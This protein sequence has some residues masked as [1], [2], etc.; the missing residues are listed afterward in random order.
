[1]VFYVLLYLFSCSRQPEKERFCFKILYYELARSRELRAFLFLKIMAKRIRTKLSPEFWAWCACRQRCYNTNAPFYTS[2]GGRGIV[3]C[4]RWCDKKHGFKNF[5]LDMGKRPSDKHSL[6]RVDNNGNYDPANCRWAT[7]IEQGNNKR[8]NVFITHNGVSL[9]IRE[10]AS[11]LGIDAELI[12]NRRKNGWSTDKILSKRKLKTIYV[13]HNDITKT[14]KEW[15]VQYKVNY[16][17]AY[18]R[19]YKNLPF[20]EIFNTANRNFVLIEN[21]G[22]VKSIKEWAVVFNVCYTTA[23]RKVRIGLPFNEIFLNNIKPNIIKSKFRK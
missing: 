12:R 14:L 13:T 22:E 2:Y 4:D 19:Y 3:V 5:L 20:E 11:V 15:S 9:S 16:S 18:S 6:D 7:S 23:V 17:M 1:M 21:N 10:W 8:N